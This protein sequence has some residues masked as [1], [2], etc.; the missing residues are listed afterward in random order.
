VARQSSSTPATPPGG[1]DRYEP[2]PGLAR[3]P[4]WAWRR[5]PRPARVAVALLPVL[6]VA[7]AVTLAPGIE[8]A[9]QG[10]AEAERERIERKRAE[11]DAGLRAEQ[12]PRFAAVPAAPGSVAGRERLVAAAAVSIEGDARRRVAENGLSGP[13]RRVE[14][15]PF[16]RTESRVGADQDPSTRYGSYAC[17]AVTAEF[18][19]STGGEAD[20]YAESEAGAVGHPYRL[21]IDFDSG[22]YAFCKVSGRAGEGAIGAQPTVTVPKV[23]GGR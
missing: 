13:I 22:R 20:A 2:L 15:E 19:A 18:G 11:R 10:R 5:L 14:C 12:R 21:R 1:E 9:K 8:D 17:L 4:A 3:L 23:C 6:A 16:P 7:L